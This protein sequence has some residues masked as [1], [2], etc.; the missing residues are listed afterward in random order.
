MDAKAL[1]AAASQTAPAAGTNVVVL[2]DDETYVFDAQGKTVH[3]TY[4]VFK[5]LTQEGIDGWSHISYSWEPWRAERPA[6]RARVIGADGEVHAL[7]PKTISDSPAADE[8]TDTYGDSRVVRAPLPAVAIGSV[9]EEEEI[10]T[11]NPPLPD[12]GIVARD[13]FGRTVPV[14]HSRLVLDAPTSLVLHYKSQLLPNLDTKREEQNGRLKITFEQGSLP[15]VDDADEDL[16]SDVP[17]YPGVTFSTGAS[18]QNLADAYGKIVDGQVAD[19]NISAIAAKLIA[20]KNTRD[21]KIEALFEYLNDQVRYTGIEFDESAIIPHPPALTLKHRYGDCKDKAVLLVA[22]LRA[23]D[24]PA[25]VALLNAGQR[26]DVPAELPGIG[27]F[28]HAIVYVPGP[29][30]LWIDATADY[31]RASQLPSPD[32][33]RLA[34]VTKAGTAALVRTSVISARDNIQV[35]ERDIYL[36]DNGPAKI[37]ETSKPHGEF[38]PRYRRNYANLQDKKVRD[39]L[40]SYFKSQYLADKLDRLDRSD[41]KDFSKPFEL[42]LESD[43]AKRGQTDLTSSV[44][45]IRFESIFSML[46]SSL[47]QREEPKSDDA[48]SSADAKKKRTAD[49]QL[50]EAFVTEW[51]YKIVPPAG[52]Q[53]KPLPKNSA[54]TFG[55]AT[56]TQDFSADPD[57]VV[58]A[59][60]RFEVAKRDF[61]IAEATE[62]RNKV[63]EIRASEPLLIYFEPAAQALLNQD[64]A[65]EAFHLYRDAIS[66][67]PKD[68]IPHLR[69]S[70]A[71]LSQ[72]LGDA[73][74]SEARLAVQLDPKSALAQKTLADVLQYDLVGRKLRPG[75]DLVGAQAAYRAA[76]KLD[77]QDKMIPA[78]L[79]ILMEYNSDGARYGR[80]ADLKGAIA[81]YRTLTP[82]DLESVGLKNNL[83]FALFYAGEFS[84]AKKAAE[85]LNPQPK[86]LLVA[87]EAALDGSQ[88]ALD[89]ARK[90]SGSDQ[91]F[92]QT[93]LTAGDMLMNVRKYPQAADLM[94][95]GASGDNA[96]QT[97]ARASMLRK[98]RLHETITYANDPGGFVM[99][100]F[101][102]SL[103]SDPTIETVRGFLSRNALVVFNNDDPDEIKDNLNQGKKFRHSLARSGASPDVVLDLLS[104]LIEPKVEGNDATGYRVS[105][106]IP[107]GKNE[108]LFVVKEDGKYKILD[109]S[110]KPNSIGLEILDRVASGDLTGARVLL[111]WEREDQHIAGGDD[112]L[113]GAAFPRIWT[114][115]QEATAEQMKIAGAAIL[116]Q[117]KP[118]AKQGVAILEPL[119]ASAP[120]DAAK[121]NIQLALAS[122]YENLEAFDKLDAVTS[123]VAK[124]YPESRLLF[125]DRS[126]ALRNLRRFDEADA[127]ANDR[128]KRLPDDVDA[129]V[130]LSFLEQARDDYPA[131][132]AFEQKIQA[133]GKADGSTLNAIAWISLF[134]AKVTDADVQTA[135]RSSQ[136][137]PNSWYILH[138]LGCLYAEVGK[139]REAHDVFLQ[140]MDLDSLDEPNLQ[141]WY[142]FGRIA[143]QFG[144]RD[145]AVTDYNKV[146]APKESADIPGSTYLLAQRRLKVLATAAPDAPASAKKN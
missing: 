74:R 86:A 93:A 92:K 41:P 7:D 31:S 47:Q 116:V 80:G 23:A 58:H 65:A 18:W 10:S 88:P 109:T 76:Q 120:N 14:Q 46:P 28:D 69:M 66:A 105:L 33:G 145:L 64:R 96:A 117:T 123:D 140:A 17:A 90:L 101:F 118:T 27:M 130:A 37:V 30:D 77:P 3:T 82:E 111:D 8:D 131:A 20:G 5:V 24:I 119:L 107:G 79:A 124:Q 60:I 97:A 34:L 127:L 61:S 81:E 11:E 137:S 32:Q 134:T 142:G 21:E 129:Y 104:Q 59:V 48:S 126:Q 44:A 50:G 36:A 56:L 133:S 42:V 113:A 43:H 136:M 114:K 132:I 52:F 35:E 2:L 39:D 29:P 49:Y 102:V 55:P 54:L 67:R 26:E 103:S 89:E 143:E 25:Y 121:L 73:A 106:Q 108:T 122:G 19:P 72:G 78:D 45:A 95:A 70:L 75:S 1:Y 57:G 12:A 115:G 40:T 128:L 84:D 110:E 9:V 146:T 83:A 51:R 4:A 144:E 141:F 13:Y 98:A 15:A 53:P 138:T 139:T 62:L 91:E 99:N 16:P 22:L 6:I 94:D 85:P 135:I 68:A 112:P 100:Y 63:A 125:L 38:E 87:S 71:L